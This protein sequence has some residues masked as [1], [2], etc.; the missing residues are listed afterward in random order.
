MQQNLPFSVLMEQAIKRQEGILSSKGV[1]VVRTGKYTGRSPND[2]FT[3]E[4]AGSRDSVWW[5]P[6][7]QKMQPV[8]AQKL[9]EKIWAYLQTKDYFVQDC[10]AGAS[11]KHQ[12]R[13]RVI[14]ERAWHSAFA[15]NMFL[16]PKASELSSF[17]PEFTVF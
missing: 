7:N 1:S 14:T 15:K 3:V 10:H 4:D 8:V 16:E 5:G 6:I 12:L 17:E 13:V 2:K 11:Q 9:Y